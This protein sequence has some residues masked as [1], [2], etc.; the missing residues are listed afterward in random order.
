MNR[1]MTRTRADRLDVLHNL[2]QMD[3]VLLSKRVFPFFLLFLL[4]LGLFRTRW[5]DER[6]LLEPYLLLLAVV[7]SLGLAVFT[8]DL[9]FYHGILSDAFAQM[10][11]QLAFLAD[12]EQ[13]PPELEWVYSHE[14]R[15]GSTVVLCLVD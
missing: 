14:D 13:L 7:P 9:R 4:S 1:L 12:R 2:R 8:I 3:G 15:S 5:G 10:R 11:P 6:R